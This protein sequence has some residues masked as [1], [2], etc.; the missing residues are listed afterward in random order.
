MNKKIGSVGI[1]AVRDVVK[2]A[3]SLASLFGWRSTHGGAHFDI[4]VTSDNLPALLLHEF[5]A[6]DHKRFADVKR[7]TNGIGYSL[8]VFVADLDSVYQK[9][10]R[11][12]FK[13]VEKM[14]LNENTEMREFTFRLEEGYQF[15]VCEGDKWLYYNL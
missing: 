9:V 15:T 11:R 2:T 14:W 8:Y 7:R 6:H 1:I 10:R 4:L 13:I 3:K 12:K 5:D